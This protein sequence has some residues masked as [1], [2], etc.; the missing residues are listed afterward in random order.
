LDGG[1]QPGASQPI[2]GGGGVCKERASRAEV[3]GP[4]M[5]CLRRAIDL[6]TQAWLADTVGLRVKSLEF[7]V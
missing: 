3:L 1:R 7:R 2:C 5:V 4:G 6:E